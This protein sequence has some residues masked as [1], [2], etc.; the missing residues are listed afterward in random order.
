MK[1]DICNMA[2]SDILFNNT[3]SVEEL[4][5]IKKQKKVDKILLK[6]IRVIR[7]KGKL[8]GWV[9]PEANLK[10]DLKLSDKVIASIKKSL[11]E[12]YNIDLMKNTSLMT[13][14][15]IVVY[16]KTNKPNAADSIF[17]VNLGQ[18]ETDTDNEVQTDDEMVDPAI[19]NP[20]P[21]ETEPEAPVSPKDPETPEEPVATPDGGEVT[22]PESAPVI[23]Q[24][25]AELTPN[26]ETVEESEPG[27]EPTPAGEEPVAGTPEVSTEALDANKGKMVWTYYAAS[28]EVG[29]NVMLSVGAN[30]N[31]QY[32]CKV[33]PTK[34]AL[35]REFIKSKAPMGVQQGKVIPY[36]LGIPFN[37]IKKHLNR[38]GNVPVL[39]AKVKV[40]SNICILDRIPTA[41]Y[42]K[43]GLDVKPTEAKS[44][45]DVMNSL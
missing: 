21:V 36:A 13:A 17:L 40:P 1:G 15:A 24:P 42:A 2:L 6:V 19:T 28:K 18:T 39:S 38:K 27:E 30:A 8:D 45:A 20:R 5:D 41:K 14:K 35:I 37:F 7:S 32:I 12:Y 9:K 31:S 3:H 22:E 26:P 23:D 29:K 16:I 43:E 33:F 11:S 4:V 44:W 10:T 25:T 34:D